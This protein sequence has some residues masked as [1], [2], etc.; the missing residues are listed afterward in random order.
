[1]PP[2]KKK[3]TKGTGYAGAE[4]DSQNI[5]KHLAKAEKRHAKKHKETTKY[6][7]EFKSKLSTSL[8]DDV[9]AFQFLSEFLPASEEKKKIEQTLQQVFLHHSPT[10]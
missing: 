6:L 10:E 9:K 3:G 7:N 4:R 1:M 5:V 2:K 8:E